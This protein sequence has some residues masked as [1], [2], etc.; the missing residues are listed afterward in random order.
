MPSCLPIPCSPPT[1]PTASPPIRHHQQRALNPN[2]P[3]QRGTAQGPDVYMQVMP[4]PGEDSGGTEVPR[5]GRAY[6]GPGK[7][8]LD[9]P[10]VL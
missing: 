1:L 10:P 3:H 4:E 6:I 5:G 8:L 2:H 7:E 9:R